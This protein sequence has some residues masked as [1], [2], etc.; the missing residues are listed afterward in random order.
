MTVNHL[1]I[2]MNLDPR[3]LAAWADRLALSGRL[4]QPGEDAAPIG[5][6]L[7]HGYANNDCIEIAFDGP[8]RIEATTQEAFF[9]FEYAP[10]DCGIID[11]YYGVEAVGWSSP[12]RSMWIFGP[13]YRE[14]RRLT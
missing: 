11:T 8:L 14:E 2:D 3:A 5:E 4:L 6:I 10:R 7:L 12:G 1:M 9:A 13:S